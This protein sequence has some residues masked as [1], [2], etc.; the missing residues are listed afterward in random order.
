M[1][2]SCFLQGIAELL[3]ARPDLGSNAARVDGADSAVC[4]ESLQ[5]RKKILSEKME[6]EVRGK[7]GYD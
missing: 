6:L 2:L 3:R 4:W 7:Q 1:I 5:N